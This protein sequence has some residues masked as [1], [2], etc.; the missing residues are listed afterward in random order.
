[1]PQSRQLAAILFTDI[2]GYTATMQQNELKA[3]MLKDRHRQIVENEHKNFNGNIV[4]YYGDGTLSIFS[5]VV[6]AVRCAIKMQQF[7][8]QKPLVPV[9]MGLHV[10]D[11]IMNDGN[12]FGDGVNLASRIESLGVAGSVLISD[13]VHDEIRNQPDLRTISMGKYHLKNVEREVEIFAL[14]YEGLVRPTPNSLKGKTQEKKSSSMPSIPKKSVAVLPFV[15][16]SN[17]PEQEYF[18]EGI[19][20]E[21]LNSL[22][23]L[24]DLKVAGR[25]SSFQFKGKG[26]D[27]RRLGHKLGVHTVLE[28]SVRKQANRLRVTVQLINV[29]DGFHLWSEKYDREMDDIFAIQD[30]IAL[31]VTEKLK[32]TL[33]E[34]EKENIKAKTENK[35]AYDYYLKGRFYWNRRGTGLRKGLDFFLKAIELDP[36]F[37]LAHSAI[38]ETYALFA[39]HSILPPHHAIPKARQAAERAIELS[40]S[41]IEPYSVL[42]YITAFYDWKWNDAKKQFEKAFAINSEY[43]VAHYWY[44]NFLTWVE[45]DF[46]GAEAEARKAI[47]LEPLLAHSD[48]TLA[49]VY[50]CCGRFEEARILSEKAIELDTG[51]FLSY[52]SLSMALHGLGKNDKAIETIKLGA[53][54]SKGHQYALLILSWLYGTDDNIAEAEKMFDEL[55]MRSKTEFIS[56]LSLAV[57]AYASKKYDMAVECLERAFEERASL[58]ISISGYPFLSFIKTD[59]RFQSFF[60]R[61]NYPEKNIT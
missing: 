7:F 40:P 9:R 41:R 30:E 3:L 50:I 58:L 48:T 52:C 37:S 26:F 21:I 32:I 49:S 24:N 12:V 33:L 2:E 8:C 19:A 34:T 46:A 4:Q 6:N 51:S 29:E 38:A 25:T 39:F 17:D 18:S 43:A 11:I 42:A 47:Q 31:S 13:K 36:N 56:G 5:S 1:M 45:R 57:A 15:N 20:E 28:G 44:C 16:M 35:E 22:A 54:I 59:P 27:L 61:M 60:K 55:L 14:N 53:D 10:G 23:H